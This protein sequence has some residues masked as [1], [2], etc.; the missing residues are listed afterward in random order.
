MAWQRRVGLGRRVE[1]GQRNLFRIRRRRRGRK[2]LLAVV[3]TD[4]F[5]P[6]LVRHLA[7]RAAVW[8]VDAN[9]H[10]LLSSRVL[11]TAV[12]W[13]KFQTCSTARPGSANLY[14]G[15]DTCAVAA[16]RTKTATPHRIGGALFGS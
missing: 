11:R 6:V 7:A 3:T 13:S 15:E 4:R 8:A 16:T 12:P 9:S 1:V 2:D 14:Y 5:A 10:P